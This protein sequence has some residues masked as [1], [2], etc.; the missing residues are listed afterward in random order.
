MHQSKLSFNAGEV[1][2]YLRHRIDIDKADSAAELL[3][4]FVAMPYGGVMKRPG[5]HWLKSLGTATANSRL[6][7]FVASDGSRYLLHFTPDT[8]TIYD[9]AGTVKDTQNFMDGYAWG[10]FDWENSIRDLH[11]VQLNDVAF[12]THPGTFP[13]R[14]SRLSDTEWRLRFIPFDRA[15]TLDENR[16][17]T[18]T[19]TVASNPVADT[20]ADGESYGIDDKVFID[21]EWVCIGNHA[22]SSTNR[23]GTGA[24]WRDVW[25]RMFYRAG[26]A[27][28]LIC[29]ERSETAW[30]R[31]GIDYAVD[32][33]VATIPTFFFGNTTWVD[34]EDYVYV[35]EEAYN[36]DDRSINSLAIKFPD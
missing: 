29:D 32:D 7:P 3:E 36:T 15:P 21:C 9:T 24:D 18:K 31:K 35:C 28:T 30:A 12:F 6:L 26:D 13:L 20:W 25:Q 10:S 23:P 22:A 1:T 14:L 17:K 33:I 8:L 16:K 4:N 2:P 19:F 34:G 27:V 5:L 11:M